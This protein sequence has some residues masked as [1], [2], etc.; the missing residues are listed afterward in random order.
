[1]SKIIFKI[2]SYSL[3]FY[4]LLKNSNINIQS[5][6]LLLITTIYII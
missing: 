3:L 5:F 6:S 4:L 2:F 1:M